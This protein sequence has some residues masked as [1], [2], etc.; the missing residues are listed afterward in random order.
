VGEIAASAESLDAAVAVVV[1]LGRRD[2]WS[3][4]GLVADLLAL[5]GAKPEEG[6]NDPDL[7]ELGNHPTFRRFRDLQWPPA[8]RAAVA[9]LVTAQYPHAAVYALP[10]VHL[11]EAAP[12]LREGLHA[13]ARRSPLRATAP[14]TGV[15]PVMGVADVRAALAAVPARV[16]DLMVILGPQALA[17]D[18]TLALR[19][20]SCADRLPEIP[21]EALAVLSKVSSEGSRHSHR[22]DLTAPRVATPDDGRDGT[23][24]LLRHGPPHRLLPSQLAL[25]DPVRQALEV[26]QALLY[27]TPAG[28][29]PH[30]PV[31]LTLLLDVSPATFGPVETVL[32][33]LAH[34]IVQGSWRAGTDPLLLTTAPLATTVEVTRPAQLAQLWTSRSLTPPDLP[35]SVAEAQLSDRPVVLL[36]HLQTAL[37]QGITGIGHDRLT[38]VTTQTPGTAAPSTHPRHHHLPARP[39]AEELAGLAATLLTDSGRLVLGASR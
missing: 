12:V 8:A 38:V 13:S 34:L 21:A 30:A 36:T 31:P 37:A 27:R 15:A 28:R 5:T 2:L 11:D 19:L 18:P 23:P 6:L 10:S 1:A 7:I 14:V 24:M 16:L 20:S 22:E 33:L 9:A 29:P 35:Q 25:P 3:P 4:L 32:R 39:T 17:A 26:G